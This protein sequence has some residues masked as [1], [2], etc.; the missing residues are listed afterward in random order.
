MEIKSKIS[1][2]TNLGKPEQDFIYSSITDWQNSDERKL[3]LKSQDY[4]KN[5]N[6][7]K[8]RKRYYIDRK[9]VQQEATNLSNTKLAHPYLR[10]LVN[11]KVNYLLSKP[12]TVQTDD[13][14]FSQNLSKYLN[15]KFLRMLKNIGRDSVV[16]GISWIQVFYDEQGLLSFK[17]IPPEEIIPFW[18]DAEHT[19]LSAVIRVYSMTQYL[20][21]GYKKEVNKVEYHTTNGV[22]YYIMGDKGLEPDPE[23]GKDVRGHFIYSEQKVDKNGKPVVGKDGKP[24]ETDVEATWEKVPFIAFKYNADELGLLK[25]TKTLIDDYDIGTSNNSNNLNDIPNSIKVVRNYD[26][27]DKAEFT[28]NLNIYR[29]AFVSGDGDVTSLQTPLDT[30]ASDSHLNRLKKDIYEAGNG[31]DTQDDD[32][33]NASGVALKFRYAGLEMDTSDMANEFSAAMEE[34]I[35]FIT[36]DMSSKGIGDYT[37]VD[38][39]V[40]F[41]TDTIVNESEIIT[42]AMNSVGIISDETI[43]ANHPWVSDVE[44]ELAKLKTQKEEAQKEMMEMEAQ[45]MAFGQA[46]E[47]YPTNGDE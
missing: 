8:D 3:M 31:V 36:V 22:W 40:I 24:V 47:Q 33:G 11:Q 19:V 29:T 10:K 37:E 41:N 20:P 25:F 28:Q 17:R 12:L 27:V 5:D 30:E 45:A 35:W 38:F 39:E 7:I 43:I 46:R 23:M 15:K 32:L 6:D 14:M 4:Y 18:S 16:N 1:K 9:G 34:L 2:L 21:N 42:D 26:G 44:L 13:D